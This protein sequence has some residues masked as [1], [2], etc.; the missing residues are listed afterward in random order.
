MNNN[1]PNIIIIGQLLFIHMKN[2]SNFDLKAQGQALKFIIRIIFQKRIVEAV[3]S[4]S[5]FFFENESSGNF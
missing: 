5:L 2:T 3:V 1:R 4:H